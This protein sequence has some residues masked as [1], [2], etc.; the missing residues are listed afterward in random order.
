MRG[1]HGGVPAELK[2]VARGAHR[3]YLVDCR[4]YLAIL[5]IEKKATRRLGKS[6]CDTSLVLRD[7]SFE[8]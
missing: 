3:Q 8:H 4:N 2:A 6:S 7:V 1:A 5:K